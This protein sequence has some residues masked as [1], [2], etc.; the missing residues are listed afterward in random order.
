MM[1]LDSRCPCCDRAMLRT[2]FRLYPRSNAVIHDGLVLML[3]AVQFRVVEI[4]WAAYPEPVNSKRLVYQ[5]YEGTKG[6]YETTRKNLSASIAVMRPRLARLGV[7]IDSTW[8]AYFLKINRR[9]NHAPRIP[10]DAA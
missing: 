2:N 1:R 8:N 10:E 5:V 6:R 7:A 3:G 9:K 4:L